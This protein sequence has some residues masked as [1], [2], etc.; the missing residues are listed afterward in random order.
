[1]TDHLIPH[2]V[3]G[4]PVFRRDTIVEIGGQRWV[5]LIPE[6]GGDDRLW[7]FSLTTGR[8]LRMFKLGSPTG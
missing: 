2:Q 3:D 8:V 7:E 5:T 1:M 6:D 4:T